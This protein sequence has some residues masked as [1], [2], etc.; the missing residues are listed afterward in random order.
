M[1]HGVLRIGN[2]PALRVTNW[3]HYSFNSD[4]L[5]LILTF[6]SLGINPGTTEE[7]DTVLTEKFK[8]NCPPDIRQLEIS[9]ELEGIETRKFV[10]L[11]IIVRTYAAG[12]DV[13]FLTF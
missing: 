2:D 6:Q 12:F 4:D 10:G 1:L 9:N 7:L 8:N 11:F 3:F 5:I 13:T